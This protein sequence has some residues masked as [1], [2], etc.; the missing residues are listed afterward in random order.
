MRAKDPFHACV[1]QGHCPTPG[2]DGHELILLLSLPPKYWGDGQASPGP[3]AFLTTCT[4]RPHSVLQLRVPSV[5]PAW[6]LSDPSSLALSMGLPCPGHSALGLSAP[7]LLELGIQLLLLF[8]TLAVPE[9][10]GLPGRLLGRQDL[11]SQPRAID[12]H[13]RHIGLFL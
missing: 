9:D 4:W 6:A 1:P 12:L 10:S 13:G 8:S 3:A 2:L 7:S 11:Q 5:R